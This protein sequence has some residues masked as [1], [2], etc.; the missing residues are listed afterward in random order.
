[1]SPTPPAPAV[2]LSHGPPA[3]ARPTRSHVTLNRHPQPECPLLISPGPPPHPEKKMH[4]NFRISFQERGTSGLWNSIWGGFQGGIWA[5]SC[6][7]LSQ[8]EQKSPGDAGPPGPGPRPTTE[9]GPLSPRLSGAHL[10][11][12]PPASQKTRTQRTLPACLT[13]VEP[14]WGF[15]PF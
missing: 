9:G 4:M 10:S 11:P 6:G 5:Y 7:V 1:M 14:V 3:R 15:L 13:K 12:S 8:K 2:W